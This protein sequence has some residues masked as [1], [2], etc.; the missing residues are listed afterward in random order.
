MA[1]DPVV[2]PVV[3]EQRPEWLPSN[4]TDP[5]DLAK[6][7]KDTQGELTRSNQALAAERSAREALE[8]QQAEAAQTQ[9]AQVQQ[10]D[11]VARIDQARE[12][13]DT[14]TELALIAYVA[15][16]AAA[17]VAPQPSGPALSPNFVVDYASRAVAEKHDDWDEY[18]DKA[19]QF[20]AQ[21]SF[22]VTDE[23]ASDPQLLAQRLDLAYTQVKAADLLNGTAMVP[24]D[25]AE[26][27]RQAKLAAQ[28]L[29]GAN[30]RPA[31]ATPDVFQEIKSAQVVNYSDLFK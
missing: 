6:S 27:Q 1:D 25:Q 13:G 17:T 7:W 28:T 9:Q 26:A 2:D 15:Q 29:Q 16:Q 10:N 8:A 3:E 11:I 19:A 23:V 14:Q 22:L 18:K 12:N 30:G 4:F 5:A 24:A 20:L 21:N 31:P